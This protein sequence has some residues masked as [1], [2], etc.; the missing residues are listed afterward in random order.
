MAT[1]SQSKK[2]EEKRLY[3]LDSSTDLVLHKGFVGLGLQEILKHSSV[4]KGSFYHYFQSKEAFG[5]E[6]LSYY[7][8]DYQERLALLWNNNQT[9]LQKI[10]SYFKVWIEDENIGEG[11][12]EKC[13]IVKLAAEV[14][15]LSEDMRLIMDTGVQHLLN[16]I[17]YLIKQGKLDGSIT[18]VTE[19]KVA[20]QVIYQM[21]LGA[22]L[23]SKLQKSKTPL[24]QALQATEHMLNHSTQIN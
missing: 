12:A 14:A 18:V 16:Q 22:A 3:I 4:P 19:P 13:L 15:D 2:S 7:I 21:W 8:T 24:H 5:C 20:A 17:T 11:W 1:T 10:L 9:P 6:L 23:L